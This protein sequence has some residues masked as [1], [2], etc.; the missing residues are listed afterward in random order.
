[1]RITETI[2]VL[3]W[4]LRFWLAEWRDRERTKDYEFG[5]NIAKTNLDRERKHYE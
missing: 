2:I 3:L 1:M 4:S 5:A